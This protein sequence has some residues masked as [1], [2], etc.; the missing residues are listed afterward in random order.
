MS[1]DSNEV[2]LATRSPNTAAKLTIPLL[3]PSAGLI[4][5]ATSQSFDASRALRCRYGQSC[6][7][8]H[9]IVRHDPSRLAERNR[10]FPSNLDFCDMMYQFL[11]CGTCLFSA[12]G[13]PE[14]HEQ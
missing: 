14:W 5:N 9:P 12:I 11:K 4:W 2:T 10:P 8:P 3:G 6:Y 1:F 13:A 7:D